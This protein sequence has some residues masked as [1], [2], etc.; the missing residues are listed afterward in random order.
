VGRWKSE[1]ERGSGSRRA[2][3]APSTAD[4]TLPAVERLS[5]AAW[6]NI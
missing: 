4:E 2:D 6:E 5:N 3:V 1:A